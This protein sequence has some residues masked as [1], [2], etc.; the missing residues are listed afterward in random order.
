MRHFLIAC[1]AA[2]AGCSSAA[3]EGAGKG[4]TMGVVGGAVAGAVSS[5]IFGGNVV[6]GAAQGAA[7]GAASGAA[8]GAVA[9][10]MADSEAKKRAA[11]P[12]GD[13]ELRK[14]IGDRNYA[15]ALLLAQCRH[16]DAISSAQ[17]TV[18][19]TKDSNERA[20]ALLLQG[21]AAEESGDKT[22][23]ASMYP[24]IAQQSGGSVD[25]A[26]ADALEG[27]IKVQGERRK[28]GMPPCKT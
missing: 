2:V 17:D 8:T 18:D 20:F 28:H 21:I 22:L 25:K 10:S 6:Q 11:K 19:S 7:I 5:L 4:A 3:Q 27:V 9:G 16:K 1:V 12:A 24:K 23:A 14:R 26:R 15:S 13:A